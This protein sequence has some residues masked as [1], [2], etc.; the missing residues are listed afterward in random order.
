MNLIYAFNVL[1]VRQQQQQTTTA[2][3]MIKCFLATHVLA[4][5]C[6]FTAKRETNLSLEHTSI[7]IL[8][9]TEKNKKAKPNEKKKEKEKNNTNPDLTSAVCV[10]GACVS[11][12]R[13]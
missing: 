4:S 12:L 9:H 1:G 11:N 7:Y 8:C 6:P 2:L 13:I 10:R 5:A 3:T